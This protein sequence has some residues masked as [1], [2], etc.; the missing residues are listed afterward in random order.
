VLLDLMPPP[1]MAAFGWIYRN[2]P[3]AASMFAAWGSSIVSGFLVGPAKVETSA[4]TDPRT[5]VTEELPNVVKIEKCRF[6]KESGNCVGMCT[7]LCK[8]PSQTLFRDKVGLPMSMEPNFEDGSCKMVWGKEPLPLDR[9]E[10]MKEPCK[11]T[12]CPVFVETG[13]NC[14]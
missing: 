1:I 2:D 11:S 14:L 10:A 5:G 6:L 7:N 3:R 9:D 12:A 4:F 13:E 8:V